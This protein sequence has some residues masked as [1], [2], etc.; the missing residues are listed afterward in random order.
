MENKKD[1][2]SESNPE[3]EAVKLVDKFFNEAKQYRQTKEEEWGECEEFYA[4]NQW[5]DKNRSFKNLIFP[6]VEQEIST[7]MDSMPGTD[8]L[9]YKEGQEEAAKILESAIHFVYEKE[10]LFIKQVMAIRSSLITGTGFHYVDFDPDGDRGQGKVIIKVIPWKHVYLDPAASEIDEAAFVGIKFPM[11]VEEA[12]RKFPKFAEKI[13]PTDGSQDDSSWSKGNKEQGVNYGATASSAEDRYKLEG[14][15]TLEE[16][17]LRDYEMVE[18]PEEETMEEIKKETEEFFK[19]V[20]P[21]IGRFEDHEKHMAAHVEQK[22]AIMA[23]AMASNPG[24]TEE[25][26]LNDPELGVVLMM[27]DDHNKIHSQYRQTNPDSKKP[28]FTDGLRLVLKFGNVLVYD[29]EAPVEDGMVPLV[30]YYC[31]KDS[32]IWATGEVKHVLSSQK[33]FNEMDNAEYESLH[34]TSNPGW[35]MDAD[36]GVNPGSITNKRGQVFIKNP[37]K[38]FRRL[39]PGQTSPQ[40]SMRKQ[41]DQQ[42][43]EIISGMNEASQGRRPGGVTAAK[44]IERLQQQTNGRLRLKSTTN[45]MYSMKRLGDLVSSRI[46]KYWTVERHMRLSDSTTGEIKRVIF[47]PESVKNLEYETRTVPGTLSGTDK[48]A[49]AEVMAAYVEK[50]WLPPKVYF[51]V[52]DVPNKK[53]ILEALDQA[54]QQMAMLQQLQAENEQLKQLINGVPAEQGMPAEMARQD[55]GNVLPLKQGDY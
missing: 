30:T 10:N 55:G 24:A 29:G 3:A 1:K 51:Q 35:V 53:K 49:V 12:R 41:S 33:S 15:T 7:L 40:L 34:L 19:G 27:I 22:R 17:W 32:D 54:D 4:G 20:N 26:I 31:Y 28:K 45:Q 5:K 50:G 25:D 13:M 42:Y 43:M 14:M 23:E 39:E 9:S 46:V 52:I 38:E 37:G 18:I 11:R 8:V 44:A 6:L 48:E 2:M 36:S 16:A 21:D 47:D